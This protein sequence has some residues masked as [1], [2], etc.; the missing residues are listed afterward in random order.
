MFVKSFSPQIPQQSTTGI[1]VTHDN[2]QFE[3]QA[4]LFIHQGRGGGG[5]SR[6]ISRKFLLCVFQT[7]FFNHSKAGT[8]W[9]SSICREGAFYDVCILYTCD[10]FI[11]LKF[12]QLTILWSEIKRWDVV[13]FKYEGTSRAARARASEWL[14]HGIWMRSSVANTACT[15]GRCP[16]S[17]TTTAQKYQT[18][19]NTQKSRCPTPVSSPVAYLRK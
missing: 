15:C 10:P 13:P 18:W 4:T 2:S 11:L 8:R 7:F 6:A 19:T 16:L 9:A 14:S 5:R 12:Q 17:A 1:M 3:W